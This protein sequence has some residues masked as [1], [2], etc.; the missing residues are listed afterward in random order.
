MRDGNPLF[1]LL[2]V[3]AL[4]RRRYHTVLILE[5]VDH[6]WMDMDAFGLCLGLDALLA[7]LEHRLYLTL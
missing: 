5:R 1:A 4:R 3:A 6:F 7:L 2:L